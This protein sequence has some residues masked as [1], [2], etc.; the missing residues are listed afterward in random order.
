MKNAGLPVTAYTFGEPRVG[1]QA[2]ADTFNAAFPAG[3][4]FRV[5]HNDD[6]VPLVPPQ[7]AL[8][9]GYVHEANEFFINTEGIADASNIVICQGD[10]DG[11]CNDSKGPV[12]VDI[13]A[14]GLYMNVPIIPL[15]C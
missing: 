13:L 1:N 3:S 10:E 15:G 2:Y 7:G 12:S 6:P 4:S 9:G 14:H 5:T 8:F 11:S